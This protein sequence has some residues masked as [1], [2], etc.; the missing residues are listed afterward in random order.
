M[1]QTMQIEFN[2]ALCIHD[3]LC[4]PPSILIGFIVSF[5]HRFSLS[6]ATLLPTLSWFC[7]KALSSWET[8][9]VSL[10]RSH[11]QYQATRKIGFLMHLVRWLSQVLCNVLLHPLAKVFSLAEGCANTSSGST[12]MN[13]SGFLFHWYPSCLWGCHHRFQFSSQAILSGFRMSRQNQQISTSQLLNST[14]FS[15]CQKSSE[16]WWVDNCLADLES[17]LY[18]PTVSSNDQR[19]HFHRHQK[20]HQNGRHTQWKTNQTP[21]LASLTP[22]FST[23]QLFFIG[24]RNIADTSWFKRCSLLENWPFF[25]QRDKA[26]AQK[27]S[28]H[29]MNTIQYSISIYII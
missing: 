28:S 7:A 9:A 24:P 29:T 27:R 1:W 3:H 26:D 22:S 19:C 8:C 2:V 13:L 14:L 17:P 23:G 20:H 21:Y 4:T 16:V 25:G 12:N 15:A 18:L 6:S 11:Q 5:C 10:G